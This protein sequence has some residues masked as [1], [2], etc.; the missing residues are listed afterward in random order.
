VACLAEK[1]GQQRWCKHQKL[2][3]WLTV[4][5]RKSGRLCHSDTCVLHKIDTCV[6]HKSDTVCC[7]T[8][9]GMPKGTRDT[10]SA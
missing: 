2:L 4:Q 7:T 3:R 8:L 5:L 10:K 9:K 1:E 6:L